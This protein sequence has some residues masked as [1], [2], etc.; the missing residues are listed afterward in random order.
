VGWVA[1]PINSEGLSKTITTSPAAL[2]CPRVA[3]LLN[4]YPVGKVVSFLRKEI[5]PSTFFKN[6]YYSF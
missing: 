5:R 4:T 3:S 2:L 1:I 6:Q